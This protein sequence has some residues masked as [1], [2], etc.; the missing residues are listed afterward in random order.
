MGGGRA[1]YGSFADFL[2]IP[3]QNSGGGGGGEEDSND[4]NIQSFTNHGVSE[5]RAVALSMNGAISF[6]E[7]LGLSDRT[8]EENAGGNCPI[9]PKNAKEGDTYIIP[10]GKSRMFDT[11]EYKNGKWITWFDAH[12]AMGTVDIGPASGGKYLLK[13]LKNPNYL[14]H[15]VKQLGKF[16]E[17][18]AKIAGKDGSFTTYYRYF[19]SEGKTIKFFH[20]TYDGAGKFLH[21][22]FM[23]GK[24][25]LK[26]WFDGTRQWFSKW[27]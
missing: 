8:N 19:N 14:E 17:Y 1:E 27:N 2:G 18:T 21:R 26:I 9:C 5:E 25:R 10:G 16:W 4:A 23:M 24:E 6:D 7:F 12:T 3:N 15:S 20:D 22:E 11:Y 13:M